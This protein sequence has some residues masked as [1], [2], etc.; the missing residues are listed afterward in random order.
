MVVLDDY[1]QVAAALG[2]WDRL[3][4]DLDLV[5]VRDHVGDEDDLVALL[6]GAPVVVAMRER[7][8]FPRRVLERLPDLRLLVTTGSANVAI[9]VAAARERGVTV[10]GTGSLTAAT[11]EHTW[12][13][14]LALARGVP[15]EE[16]QLRAGGWQLGL[17]K[18]LEGATLGVVGLGRLG[19]RVAEVGQAFG[20]HVVAWS[21]HLDPDAAR[22][23]G[24]EPVDK[25]ELFARADVV[26]LH[27]VL[28]DRSRGTV[29]AAELAAMKPDALLVNTSRGPLVDEAALVAALHEGRLGGAALDV[30][31]VEPL[32]ADSPL[33]TAPRLVLTPHLGYV[34][35]GTYRVFFRDVVEDIAAWRDGNPLREL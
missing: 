10:S 24:V 32:P 25:A 11:A 3:G 6:A 27:L 16:R 15:A 29:G 2:P 26:T 4:P 31:D 17:G 33:R 18:D 14:L 35:E 1:Q 7:T 30:Y 20:M 19:S 5:C 21:Q 9:D 28:S 34:T 8:A 13:L 23:A 12:A 22:A